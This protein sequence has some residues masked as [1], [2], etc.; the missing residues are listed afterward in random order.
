MPRYYVI[1]SKGVSAV[2]NIDSAEEFPPRFYGSVQYI[3]NLDTNETIKDISDPLMKML[4]WK[5]PYIQDVPEATTILASTKIGFERHGVRAMVWRVGFEA[6]NG[7]SVPPVES[8]T[9]YV[10]RTDVKRAT[11]VRDFSTESL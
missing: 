3:H 9:P 11:S 6:P 4:A 7:F 2:L 5:N 10:R 8:L 1:D